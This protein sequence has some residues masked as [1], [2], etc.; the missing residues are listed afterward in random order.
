MTRRDALKTLLVALAPSPP[1]SKLAVSTLIGTGTRRVF[2]HAGQQPVRPGHW[3]GRR[4]LF[5]RSR[6]PADPAARSEDPPYDH[7]RRQRSARIRGRRRPGGRRVAQHAARDPVR[8]RVATSTS[9]SATTTSIRK[10][11][12]KTGIIS[13]L[14]GTGAAGF[15]G[16][17][18][19]AS[20]AQLRQPHSIAVEPAGGSS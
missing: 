19:P 1:A 9:P 7:D 10:V 5:L 16:D 17:G 2:R 15:S 4:A 20:A 6:Q 18:G 3:T 11:E 14:A 13:T 12:A 8:R